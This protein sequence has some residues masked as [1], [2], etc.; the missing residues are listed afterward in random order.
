MLTH[1][2][3]RRAASVALACSILSSG[4][5][6]GCKTVAASGVR[7][8]SATITDA[9]GREVGTVRFTD[10]GAVGVLVTGT[11]SNLPAGQHGIHFHATGRCDAAGAFAS[12][13]GHFNPASRKHG[14]SNPDGPHA[15][16]LPNLEIGTDMTGTYRTTTTRISLGND[17]QSLLDADGSAVVIHAASD[18]QRTDPAGNSGARV[19]CGVIKAG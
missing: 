12:A 2:G 19:A 11:F 10:L 8:A 5:A 7:T 17:A 16:D 14:L 13:G 18:D 9:G 4:A 1:S 6:I 3:S 15:G